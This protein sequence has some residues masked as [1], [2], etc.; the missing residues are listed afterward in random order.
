M[1]KVGVKH[2]L[3]YNLQFFADD[4]TGDGDGSTYDMDG[5]DN[6]IN[7]MGT[8]G[9]TTPPPT[10]DDAGTGE[11]PP[12]G[13]QTPPDDQTQTQAQKNDKQQFAFAQMRTQNAQYKGLLDKIA[14]AAG[15]EYTND[16]DLLTKLNDDAI[17]K[18]AQKQGV[19]A[20]LLKRMEDLE[21]V[22]SL[23]E[24]EQLKQSA[25][26]GFQKLMK[27][28]SL[29]EKELQEFAKELDGRGLNPFVMKVDLD[30][31]YRLTHF[32]EI[33]EKK[34][35][36]GIEQALKTSNAA[37]QHSSTPNQKTGK[38]GS[39]DGEKISTVDGL[40]ALLHDYK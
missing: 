36:A 22:K 26:M 10:D 6:L 4:G 13:D 24:A 3:P 30:A 15:I 1:K 23:Y 21:G 8:E 7:G 11:Q 20:E 14:K 17:G 38:P 2:V 29:T 18:L 28:H 33:I 31:E 32:D 27:E 9:Q 40:S 16:T 12:E 19:P 37:D 25:A 35:K 34:V 39:S 5:L